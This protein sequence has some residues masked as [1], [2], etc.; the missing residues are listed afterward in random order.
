[1]QPAEER[2]DDLLWEWQCYAN[3]D[4]APPAGREVFVRQQIAT[5]ARAIYCPAVGQSGHAD[6]ADPPSL[7]DLLMARQLRHR[8]EALAALG[9]PQCRRQAPAAR[10][11]GLLWRYLADVGVFLRGQRAT[12]VL[13]NDG[14]IAAIRGLQSWLRSQIATMAITVESNP[15]SNIHIGDM[16]HMATHPA[17]V[18]QPLHDAAA[19]STIALSMNTD[20]PLTFASCLTDEY[21]YIYTALLRHGSTTAEAL[22]WLDRAREAGWRSRFSVAASANPACLRAITSA[23]P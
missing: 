23:R 12:T 2:L 10:P 11:Y 6:D 20:N 19:S 4:I 22:A 9:Y 18:L 5:L 1:M 15:S 17:L 13:M 8:L 3:A 21:L 7:D 14:E 16:E